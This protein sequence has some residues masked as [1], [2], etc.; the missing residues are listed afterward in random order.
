[1]SEEAEKKYA[2]LHSTATLSEARRGLAATSSGELVLFAG[3]YNA[4]GAS[5]RVDI[6]NVSSGIWTTTALSLNLVLNLQPHPHEIL[7]YLVEV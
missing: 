4:I 2:I 3:G 6:L 5:A 7:S 1:M